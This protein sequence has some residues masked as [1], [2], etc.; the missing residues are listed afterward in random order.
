MLIIDGEQARQEILMSIHEAQHTIRIRMYM[1]RDDSAGNM[2]LTALIQKIRL[3]PNIEVFIEKDAFGSLVYNLQKWISWGKVRG[4]IFSGTIGR[5]LLRHTGNIHLSYIGSWSPLR[6]IYRRENDHSKIFLFD[7]FTPQSRALIW[8]MNIADHHL[9]PHSPS[10]ASPGGTHDYMVRV[11]GDLADMIAQWQSNSNKKSIDRNIDMSVEIFMT[12][13]K[14]YAMRKSI[15]RELSRAKKS[16]IIEHGCLTDATIIRWLRQLSYR[17]ITV[18]IILP[19][20]SQGAWHANMH[21]IHRLLRPSRIYHHKSENI[22]VYLYPG[23][24]HAKV[25][26]IDASIAIIGSAN[27]TRGS[28]DI[29]HE[30]NAIF[31]GEESEV[32]R[33]LVVQLDQD[34]TLSRQITLETIPPYLRFLAWFQS[35]FI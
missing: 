15:M 17:G 5:D 3:F 10:I 1:W 11:T 26:L 22:S 27:F 24:V 23:M 20:Y 25:T 18:Q 35:L 19:A 4:D 30:T 6:L 29:L 21:S 28:F 16:I 34:I 14:R 2:I 33:S 31:R 7:E 9:E 8:G 12:I 32:V 13:K